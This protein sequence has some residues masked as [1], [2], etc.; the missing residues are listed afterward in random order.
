MFS[1]MKG[2]LPNSAVKVVSLCNFHVRQKR[3]KAIPLRPQGHIW[4]LER[5]QYL[6]TLFASLSA[7]AN[8][9]AILAYLRQN[10]TN[11]ECRSVT[12][13]TTILSEERSAVFVGAAVDDNEPRFGCVE[14]RWS[15]KTVRSQRRKQ[16]LWFTFFG[17]TV[18]LV[19]LQTKWSLSTV[20]GDSRRRGASP[21][22]RT[23]KKHVNTMRFVRPPSAFLDVAFFTLFTQLIVAAIKGETCYLL[24]KLSLNLH[25]LILDISIKILL[26]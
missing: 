12:K 18:M 19:H 20:F 9:F 16:L 7:K 25:F 21:G 26:W 2:T 22:A 6:N 5:L 8:S 13:F 4:K 10:G 3:D 1:W 15:R 23:D 24:I 17:T 11:E 14:L